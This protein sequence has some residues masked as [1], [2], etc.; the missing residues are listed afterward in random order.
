MPNHSQPTDYFAKT[1][2]VGLMFAAGYVCGAISEYARERVR[3]EIIRKTE[4]S[5]IHQKLSP[6]PDP[7]SGGIQ[8]EKME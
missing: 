7:I 5:V 4:F 2:R 8:P 6:Y 3:T 1:I